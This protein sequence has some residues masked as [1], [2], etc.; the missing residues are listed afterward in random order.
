MRALIAGAVAAVLAASLGG[1]GNAEKALGLD[2]EAP[3]EFAVVTRAPL[4]LP[5]EYNL[6][7]PRPGAT[8]PQEMTTR[9]Q[10]RRVVTGAAGREN[11]LLEAMPAGATQGERALLQKAGTDQA[12]ANIRQI[13]DEET[14]ALARE[15][16]GFAEAL[17]FWRQPES[18][19]TTVDAAAESRRLRATQ[20]L[21]QPVTTGA[22]PSIERRDRG[23]LE[24]VF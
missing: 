22:S 8:R 24:G 17:L 12:V 14:S 10:A 4:S 20:A 7:P 6:R 13:V 9:D 5:P 16:E 19:G 15:G 21:G 11:A 3:D 18:Y 2:R 1:C 23:I